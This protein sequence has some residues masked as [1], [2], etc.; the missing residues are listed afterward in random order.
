[1]SGHHPLEKIL[2]W[3]AIAGIFFLPFI[4]LFVARSLFFPYITGK[5]FTFRI[6]VELIGACWLALAIVYPLYRPRR[7]W[8]FLALT[9]FVVA[10]G[11]ADVLGVNPAKSLWSNYERMDGWVTLA[12]LFVYFEISKEI[13]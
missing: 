12:H 7:S 8:I 10:I 9:V 3:V 11:L 1:M 2:R 6:L 5:N 4:V 13:S